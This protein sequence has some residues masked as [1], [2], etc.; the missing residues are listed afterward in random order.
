M[1]KYL[2]RLILLFAFTAFVGCNSV[3]NNTTTYFGGKIINPK[4]NHVVLYS[5]EKVIDTLFL[6]KDN[7]FLGKIE[8]DNEGL[9][10]F[11]HGN[12]KQHVYLESADSVMIRLNTWDFDESLVFAGKGAERNNIL[13]D[14]FLEEENDKKLF[15]EYNKLPP[16]K[17]KEKIDSLID[18]KLNT[19]KEYIDK[20][21]KETLGFKQ[22]LKTALTFPIYSRIER[23]PILNVKY[24]EDGN[25]P[26]LNK[27]FYNY[28]N[29]ISID[30]D[31]L[32]YY[33]PYSKY[34][35][36]YL[37]NKT[38]AL[39]HAPI[40]NKYSSE[41]TV[42]LLNIID[43]E[44]TTKRSKNAFLRQTIIS[45]F[46][47]KSNCE[48]NT[49][50]FNTFFTLTTSLEDKE[51]VNKLI[52]DTKAITTNNYLPN[53]SL[54][55]YSNTKLQVFDIVKGKNT[56]LFFWNPKYVSRS[57]I[58]P[59]INYLSKTYPNIK[60]IQILIQGKKGDRI[61]KLDIKNQFYLDHNSEAHKFLTSKMPRSILI[62]KQGKV[63]NG[64]GS[65]SP[66]N[67]E[68]YLKKLSKN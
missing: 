53:F 21:P 58:I 36:Y 32:M 26:T 24:T 57:Y 55:N 14:C 16:I 40:K 13:I 52:E 30:K 50:A 64:Y 56:L 17:F 35:R 27:T 3:S 34:I 11:I 33:P 63:I 46:Y 18:L 59:R 31:S 37:Y 62:N 12:E 8:N 20:H 49:K 22:T 1:I 15:Y 61:Q 10:Y 65:I 54:V 41:F 29:K 4:S 25:F 39:G 47:N 60:F 44:I 2:F 43:K 9:Y 23:Y 5:M 68:P 67:L 38:Y 48:L 42:D 66:K 45:H 7:K 51:L 6:G 19:Y 28:R